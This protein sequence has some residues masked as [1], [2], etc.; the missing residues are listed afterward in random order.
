MRHAVIWFGLAA[1]L[2]AAESANA[3]TA[4]RPV[5]LPPGEGRVVGAAFS[6]DGSRLALVRSS[7][8][9]GTSGPRHLLQVVE[10]KSGRE[11]VRAA[12]VNAEPAHLATQPHHLEYSPDGRYLLFITEGSDELS[13]IDA[14]TLRTVKEVTLHPERNSRKVLAPGPYFKGAVS[15]AR[16][17][18]DFF[19]V[20]T[21]DEPEG[22]NE[23]FVGSFSSGQILKRWRLGGG[24]GQAGAASVSLSED[25]ASLVVSIL[26]HVIESRL[27]KGLDNLR[28]F[29]SMTGDLLKSVRAN[30]PFD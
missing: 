19:G 27:P 12:A 6:P 1:S 29:S 25:G 13:L 3:V 14:I 15:L 10:L 4:I 9:S 24:P 22:E 8:A 20:L 2:F 17:S 26:P 11:L 23:V 21:H 5:A 18:G 16:S 30:A 7:A 28:L